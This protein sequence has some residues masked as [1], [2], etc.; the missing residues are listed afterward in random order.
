MKHAIPISK[1]AL[2][3]VSGILQIIQLLFSLGILNI[4]DIFKKNN[5]PA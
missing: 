4:E 3:P 5:D 1:A 2:T